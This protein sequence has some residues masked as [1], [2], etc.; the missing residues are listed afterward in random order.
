MKKAKSSEC[1]YCGKDDNVSNTIFNCPTWA[2][3]CDWM[4]ELAGD[5]ISE[6]NLLE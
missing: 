2:E 3:Q 6:R 4:A 5:D 1:P